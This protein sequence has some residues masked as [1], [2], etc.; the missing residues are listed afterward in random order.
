MTM[1]VVQV[2][3]ALVVALPSAGVA[4]AG[5]AEQPAAIVV[6]PHVVVDSSRGVDTHVRLGNTQSSPI[7][8]RCFYEN[9]NG[10]CGDQFGAP[11]HSD[12][13]CP[14][15]M[16]C[17]PGYTIND[18]EM[19]LT[20]NQPV[21]W[22]ASHGLS[23]LPCDPNVPGPGCVGQSSGRVLPVSE[24]PFDGA[25]RCIAVDANDAPIDR[26]ALVGGATIE[27]LAGGPSP[28]FDA[29]SYNAVGFAAVAGGSNFDGA[30]VLGGPSAEY[31]GCP[32]ET[33][34]SHFFDGA[35]DPISESSEVFTTLALVPCGTDLA[36]WTG[37]ALF[38]Q[39]DIVNEFEERF[40][41]SAPMIHK[42]LET[43]SDIDHLGAL[44]PFQAGVAGTLTGRTIIRSMGGG[45]VGVA[46]EEHRD[47][48]ISRITSAA[49]NSH[50]HGARA[51][52]DQL[53]IP[54]GPPPDPNPCAAAPRCGCRWSEKSVLVMRDQPDDLRDKL[55]WKWLRGV[56]TLGTEFGDP[57]STTPYA[58]CMY[59][60]TE[61]SRILHAQVLPDAAKWQP[62]G[63]RGFK[64]T[65]PVGAVDGIRKVLL[66]G[67]ADNKSKAIVKGKGSG[68]PD[69]SLAGL[70]LPLTV[71]LVNRQTGA[72]WQ[73]VFATDDVRH[74]DTDSLRAKYV[75]APV[76]QTTPTP[77]STCGVAV[78]TPTPIPPTP[79]PT[80]CGNGTADT[81]LGEQCDGADL[82]GQTCVSLGF[83]GGMLA[84]SGICIFDTNACCNSDGSCDRGESPTNC[85]DDC[86]CDSDGMCEPIRGENAANCPA[87]CHC[88]NGVVEGAFG[89]QCDGADLNGQ[90]CQSFGFTT[91]T[92]NCTPTCTFDATDCHC[93]NNGTCDTGETAAN[94]P[95]DC[96]C[97]FDNTCEPTRGE[98]TVTCPNDCPTCNNNGTCDPGETAGN[99]PSDCGCDFDAVCEAVRGENS[100]NCPSDCGCDFDGACEPARGEDSS[101][102]PNDCGCDFDS[103][104]EPARGE[105][106]ANCLNDCH[107]GSGVVEVGLGEQCDGSNLNGLSCQSFGFSG[108][109]L[110]CTPACLT[111]PSLCQYTLTTAVIP[112]GVAVTS[113]NCPMGCGH[114]NGTNVPLSTPSFVAG[115]GP[116]GS[117]LSQNPSFIFLQWSSDHPGP[118]NL[119]SSSITVPMDQNRLLTANYGCFETEPDDTSP[120]QTAIRPLGSCS[121]GS[122][123]SA[124]FGAI[125][126]PSDED[127]FCEGQSV[128]VGRT[129]TLVLNYLSGYDYDLELYGPDAT[130][131]AP[132]QVF[133]QGSY[134]TG[135]SETITYVTQ[136]DGGFSA[137]VI[138][139]AGPA[140]G[141][142]QLSYSRTP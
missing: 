63:G 84:C 18:F 5:S 50:Q 49:V 36:S 28:E 58:L 10:H 67:S 4:F 88:G 55:V 106:A 42:L 121:T 96:G 119:T 97:D 39:F 32:D 90:N 75:H 120:T 123:S 30:L 89:E 87:D 9:T 22:Y 95:S 111:D 114:V 6:F 25:L 26:N 45:I 99:C 117:V 92:L 1:R 80:S 38:L 27:R 3:L 98:T 141:A 52:A 53:V 116:G 132:Q 134:G 86:G 47:L 66:K 56:A 109:N 115:S 43:L 108:G 79:T 110:S 129:I 8:V 68:L 127:W 137:R 11:C 41:V 138:R 94:C 40:S 85:P 101:N 60:G 61:Q 100:G 133:L 34:I 130:H 139:L 125:N 13:E 77:V 135:L 104:C 102:C 17:V 69:G 83:T 64:Y 70:E 73:S 12:Q 48:Q 2:L 113:P 16:A 103:T 122:N 76:A 15:F 24:D 59:A 142:Y 51:A 107:C 136:A 33:I 54:S 128:V 14:A 21:A 57:R 112:A 7:D 71:Q 118:F 91:G 65:D 20:A 72:C 46:L 35:V 37:N 124:I 82:D 23:A 44:S 19:R 78:P 131:P 31:A 81:G 93:N 126:S 62:I 29:A 105:N 74:Q 140:G